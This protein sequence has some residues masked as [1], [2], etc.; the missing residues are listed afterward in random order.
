MTINTSHPIGSRLRWALLSAETLNEQASGVAPAGSIG[1]MVPLAEGMAYAPASTATSWATAPATIDPYNNS[2][3]VAWYGKIDDAGQSV[4]VQFASGY[5]F[6]V[7]ANPWSPSVVQLKFETIW[8]G[9]GPSAIISLPDETVH[10]LLLRFDKATGTLDV[11]KDGALHTAALSAGSDPG[12]V[13]SSGQLRMQNISANFACITAQIYEG[14]LDDA[15]IASLAANPLQVFEAP[16]LDLVAV[17]LVQTNSASGGAIFIGGQ[18]FAAPMVQQADFAS[19]RIS[20]EHYLTAM[21]ATQTNVLSSGSL[22]PYGRLRGILA[23]VPLHTWV[24]VNTTRYV[25]CQMAPTDWPLGSGTPVDHVRVVIPWSSFAFDH[26]RGNLLLF[27][28][29]HA[30]YIGNE[31]YQWHA[32]TGAW[33][34]ACL[35]SWV[36]DDPATRYVVDKKAPQSSHTY[37][38]NLWLQFNR[39]FAT[40]GGAATPSGGPF[41][42]DDA[43][44]PRRVAPWV[45]DLDKTD[46][47]K[48]GGGSGSGRDPA[49]LGLEAWQHRRDHVA[50]GTWGTDAYPI[51]FGGHASQAAVAFSSGGKDYVV[52]TMDSGSGFPNWYRWEFGDIRAGESDQCIYLG[53]N[54]S[55]VATEGWMVHDSTRGLVYRVAYAKN[56]N[57]TPAELLTRDAVAATA[58]IIPVRLVHAGD[59]TGFDMTPVT[60]E[61]PYGCVYDS[62]KDCLW[63]WGGTAPDTGI[64]YRVNIPEWNPSTGWASTTWTVD[65]FTPVGNRPNGL[66]QTPILGKIKYLPE[67]G[68]FIILDRAGAA[69]DPDPGVWLF[70]TTTPPVPLSPVSMSQANAISSG[71]ID[72]PHTLSAAPMVQANHLALGA[73]PASALTPQQ[74]AWLRSLALLHGL[75]ADSPL[76]VSPT[77]R[78]AGAV[79]QSITISASSVTVETTAAPSGSPGPSALSADETRW[80]EELARIYGLIEPLQVSATERSAGTL[81]QTIG[82][83]GDTTT[84]TRA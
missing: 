32:E 40:F 81:V 12:A 35:P 57:Y 25:D 75:V 61:C 33:S 16:A 7:L 34:L 48:V 31:L 58:P 22:D 46:P 38:N 47:D 36:D 21:A 53:R 74:S 77:E 8:G 30:N 63:L 70:K 19:G 29:G 54:L 51:D 50:T 9:G 20:R 41:L 3:T 52:F 64:V 27:G 4:L 60:Q 18:L 2:I 23:G 82:K 80:L 5:G 43:G 11:F 55:V 65:T 49:R 42:E 37:Q 44:T 28:G 45:Y 79:S 24:Q 62:T 56:A 68:A 71:R 73:L 14:L 39:M 83:V 59:G 10:H 72:V 17:P 76:T 67:V 66:Y 84:V 26:A 1:S 69:G 78:V 6:R 15:E 13:G